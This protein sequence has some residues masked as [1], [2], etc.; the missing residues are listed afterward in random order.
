MAMEINGMIE[1][2]K[3]ARRDFNSRLEESFLEVTNEF[4]RIVA[5]GTYW[6]HE[7]KKRG[8]SYNLV[9]KMIDPILSEIEAQETEIEI[10]AN[11]SQVKSMK[12]NIGIKERLDKLLPMESDGPR[13]VGMWQLF[14]YGRPGVRQGGSKRQFGFIPGV[15]SN[16]FPQEGGIMSQKAKRPNL[17]VLPLGMYENTFESVVDETFWDS[18]VNKSLESFDGFKK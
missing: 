5:A 15:E 8:G 4:I 1:S 12:R 2:I 6:Y 7:P 10:E 13:T 9:P 14:E 11:G 3:A 17:G 18:I 16:R